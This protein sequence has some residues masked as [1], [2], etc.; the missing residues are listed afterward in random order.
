M[1]K[2]VVI[3]SIFLVLSQLVYSISIKELLARFVFSTTSSQINVTDYIDLMI[4]KNNNGINDTL[5]FE[6]K[7]NSNS[8][9]FIFVID[10]FDKNGIIT[11]ETEKELSQGINKLNITFNSILLNQ[12]QFNYSIKVYNSSYNLRYRK[13]NILSQIYSDYEEGF[14]I[15]NIKDLKIDKKL[16]LNV[17]INSSLNGMLEATLYLSYNDSFIFSKENA[18]MFNPIHDLIFNF[19]NETIK[20][21]H[22]IGHFNI[23]SIKIDKKIIKTNFTTAFYDFKEFA[24]KSYIFNFTDNGI[25]LNNNNKDDILQIN[26]T[27]QI[28][29][30]N[31]YTIVLALY[32]S[33]D[34]IIEIKN[35]TSFL[36]AGK[37]VI[38]VNINGSR[39]YDKRLN[40][41]FII[42]YI[43]LYENSTLIDQ[44]KDAY[45]T[46]NYNFDN[47]DR[48]NLP[49]LNVNISVSDEFN[50]GINNLSINVTF[51]NIGLKHAFNIFSEIFDNNTFSTKIALNILGMNSEFTYQINFTNFTDFEITAI[52]D[53]KDLIEE[54][55]EINN[56]EKITIK[57]NK[58]PNLGVIDNI[59]AREKDRIIINLSAYDPNGDELF[60]SINSTKFLGNSNIFVW[61][62]TLN[63]TG[64][65]T[66]SATVSDRFLNDSAIFKIVILDAIQNDFDNDGIDDGIDSLIGD[67]N[68]I[69]TSTINLTVFIGNSINLSRLFNESLEVKFLDNNLTIME[70]DFN[71]SLYRLNLTE[72]LITKQLPNETGSLFVNG[73][74]MPLGTTKTMYVDNVKTKLKSI[75]IKDDEISS[76]NEIS[77]N[78]RSA[79]EFKIRCNGKLRKSYRCSYNSTLNKYKVEGLKNSAIVQFR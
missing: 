55:S 26:V 4:D 39:I 2:V 1:H 21:T 16:E 17:S 61:D 46:N 30:D 20:R 34:N 35:M 14:R 32:D 52:V 71:F 67:K 36:N 23:S 64:D 28:I 3:F 19:Y 47:F 75:C 7:V 51:N 48:P 27:A 69:N 31:S 66:L 12:N 18:S 8:G 42:K 79:N 49:D 6:L 40:G 70:F 13:D 22:Y 72:L 56:A 77:E 78:C 58:R 29:E 59:T 24:I 63:D 45:I 50:Y 33:L 43:E 11:N 38:Y 57:L 54:L 68:S 15:F 74:K 37:N 44:I 25:D 41:P 62:T 5:V 65:Y 10:I 76:L 9:K 53:F 73:L 60:F